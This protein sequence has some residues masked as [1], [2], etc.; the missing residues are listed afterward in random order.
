[1]NNGYNL[2]CNVNKSTE[3]SSALVILHTLSHEALSYCIAGNF[4]KVFN[5][6][7]WRFCGKSPN[8]KPAN[9]ISYTVDYAE[10]LAIAKFKIHQ[11]ILKTDSPNLM[12]AKVSRYTVCDM[13][14]TPS[15]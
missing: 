2:L 8:L 10:A 14:Y 11:C 9:I 6:A 4:G 7:N 3:V 13:C 5:L 12:L 1:M 15:I